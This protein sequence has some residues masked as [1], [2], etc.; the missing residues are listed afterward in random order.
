MESAQVPWLFQGCKAMRNNLFCQ[1][2]FAHRVLVLIAQIS[3]GQ[4]NRP[5]PAFDA[6]TAHI[7]RHP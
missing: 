4:W 3:K 5:H 1:R 6:G 2:V 7:H